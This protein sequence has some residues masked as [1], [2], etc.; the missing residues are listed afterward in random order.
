MRKTWGIVHEWRCPA[1]CVVETR[2]HPARAMSASRTAVERMLGRFRGDAR[3]TSNRPH[4]EEVSAEI[5]V[6]GGSGFYSLM[7]N[8]RE[9]W[10]ETPYG[11][12][13]DKVAIGEIGGRRV[14]F[15]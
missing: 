13:S 12:P 3:R 5:G 15:L 2:V 6:F 8:A 11:S 1:D 9:A 14:A 7:E 4:M 10:V